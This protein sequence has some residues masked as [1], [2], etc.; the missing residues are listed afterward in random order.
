[1]KKKNKL[2]VVEREQKHRDWFCQLIESS[3]WLQNQTEWP[4][5]PLKIVRYE[6]KLRSLEKDNE[7]IK[8][9]G[10]KMSDEHS[11]KLKEYI[12]I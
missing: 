4:T 5:G 3:I 1:M 12:A 11:N 6:N 9:F 2:S 10:W 7:Y 8:A